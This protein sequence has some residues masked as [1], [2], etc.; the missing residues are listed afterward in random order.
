MPFS[1]QAY[2][3][4]TDDETIK[5]GDMLIVPVGKEQ[6]EMNG[7]VVSVCE[8]LRSEAPFPVE[9]AKKIIKKITDE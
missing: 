3:Y 9:K 8:C 7:N 5:V 2:S 1:E 6:K 4:I